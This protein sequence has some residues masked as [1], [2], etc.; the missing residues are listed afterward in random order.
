MLIQSSNNHCIIYNVNV[1]TITVQLAM[2]IFYK[3]AMNVEQYVIKLST[4]LETEIKIFRS[5]KKKL[6]T[7]NSSDI[8]CLMM[9]SI[10][11]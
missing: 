3:N 11:D 2:L 7:S 9:V 8:N 4:L 1:L 5:I 6:F 10:L